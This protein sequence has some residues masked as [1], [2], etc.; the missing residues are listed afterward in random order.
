M[1]RRGLLGLLGAL[2]VA[3]AGAACTKEQRCKTCGMKIDAAS[4]WRS[5]LVDA[6]GQETA[7]DT[8]RCALLAWRRGKVAAVRLRVRDYYDRNEQDAEALRFVVG[9]DVSG[10]MGPELV[11][12][13]P[14]RT[15]KFVQ[16]H[17]GGRVLSLA[18]ITE[19]SLTAKP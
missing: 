14:A 1:T 4:A 10:P 9:S 16:D 7:F 6:A 17:A 3:P 15:A 18:D 8:P 5:V 2:A 13:D 11:P 19:A 12:V